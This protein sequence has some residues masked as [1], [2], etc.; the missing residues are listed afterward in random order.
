MFVLQWQC[1]SA[2]YPVMC[3]VVSGHWEVVGDDHDFFFF[4]SQVVSI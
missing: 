4:L 1:N 2:F 3:L